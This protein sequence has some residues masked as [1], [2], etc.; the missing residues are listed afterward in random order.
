MHTQAKIAFSFV[1]YLSMGEPTPS[2]LSSKHKSFCF[3]FYRNILMFE[4]D[5]IAKGVVRSFT[6][7]S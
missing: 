4:F 3:F 7:A 1:S 5:F 2:I 6:C